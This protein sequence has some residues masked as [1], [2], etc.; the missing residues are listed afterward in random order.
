MNYT[1]Y[2]FKVPLFFIVETTYFFIC[3]APFSV[4]ICDLFQ[5]I[6]YSE[7][8]YQKRTIEMSKSSPFELNQ[9]LAA[10]EIRASCLFERICSTLVGVNDYLLV[11]FSILVGIVPFLF[12]RQLNQPHHGSSFDKIN[13]V[14]DIKLAHKVTPMHFDGPYGTV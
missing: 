10:V 12:C 7:T 3:F 1:N 13:Y 4:K 2:S 9:N 6:S 8:L 11:F 5:E 14:I